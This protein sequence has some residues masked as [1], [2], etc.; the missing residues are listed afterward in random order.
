VRIKVSDTQRITKVY[1]TMLSKEEE[2]RMR[3]PDQPAKSIVIGG[4]KPGTYYLN[5]ENSGKRWAVENEPLVTDSHRNLT[6]NVWIQVNDGPW[7]QLGSADT[8]RV[9]NQ[10]WNLK[11][12]IP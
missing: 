2:R 5:I 9:A 12:V 4:V 7:V 11:V 6:F 1:S 8:E 3:I 10:W